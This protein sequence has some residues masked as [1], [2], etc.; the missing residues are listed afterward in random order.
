M[1]FYISVP[2]E[3]YEQVKN[4]DSSLGMWFWNIAVMIAP[5]KTGNLRSA[6]TLNSNTSKLI[7]IRYNL[8]R[9]NYIKFLELGVGP[10]KKYKGF[11]ENQTRLAVLEQLIIY[12]ETAKK[13][14][15]TSTPFV[16]LKSS[17]S[18]FPQEKAF[19]RQADMNVNSITAKARSKISMIRET[20]YRQTN[21]IAL[22]SF[23]GQKV[24]TGRLKNEKLKGSTRGIST[25]NAIYN[26]YKGFNKL[27]K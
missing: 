5:Y 14:M 13:P 24:E 9:A 2:E 3:I 20:Q 22:S 12:L 25:L 17:Q 16:T 11:I 8:T 4:L 21:K 15:F 1:D 18:V 27:M 23:R 10:V 7:N 19:L 26:Q 6:I